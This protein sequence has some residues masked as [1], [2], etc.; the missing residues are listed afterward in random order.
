[1]KKLLLVGLGALLILLSGFIEPQPDA[2]TY[3]NNGIANLKKKDYISAIGDFTNA[4]SIKHDYAAA[5][6]KRAIA[7]DKLA[8]EIGFENSELCFDLTSALKY[9]SE[10][11]IPMLKNSCM[12]ECYNV[13]SAFFE[14][15]IVFCADFS[16]QKQASLPARTD[17]LVNLIKLNFFNNKATNISNDIAHLTNLIYLDISSNYLKSVSPKIGELRNLTEL[18]LNKNEISDLPTEMGKLKNLKEL[19]L[20]KNKLT[21]VPEAI[22]NMEALETLDLSFNQITTLPTGIA[23]LKNHL[24]TLVLVGNDISKSEQ[25]R[26]QKVLLPKTTIYFE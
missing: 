15:E 11:A 21:K 3:Y 22:G 19:Y 5:Y 1:M 9:G 17:E 25:S 7:K 18:H 2:T 6:Y 13:Q 4:I 16:S 23:A 14:P 12:G 8:K 20:R 26:I 10:D 24:K